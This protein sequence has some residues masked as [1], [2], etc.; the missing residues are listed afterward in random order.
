MTVHDPIPVSDVSVAECACGCVD[1][2]EPEL[3][4]RAIPHAIR[5]ATVS[6]RSH[7]PRL[8]RS[9]IVRTTLRRRASHTCHSRA[10]VLGMASR[11][12]DLSEHRR[13]G[14]VDHG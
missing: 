3:D 11:E 7:A 9:G 5:H 13:T 6:M 8:T 2:G 14:R 4:V 12:G 1:G 10:K